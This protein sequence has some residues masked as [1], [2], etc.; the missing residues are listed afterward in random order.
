LEGEIAYPVE[1]EEDTQFKHFL[2]GNSKEEIEPSSPYSWSRDFTEI[3]VNRKV[4]RRR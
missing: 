2:A 3:E 4:D 1:I